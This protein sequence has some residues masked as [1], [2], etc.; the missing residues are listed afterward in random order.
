MAWQQYGS[1]WDQHLP[2]LVNAFIHVYFGTVL[3]PWHLAIYYAPQSE[4]TIVGGR[5]SAKTEG[6]ALAWATM[7]ALNPGEDQMHVSISKDQAERTIRA[8]LKWGVNGFTETF[9]E[10]R[11]FSSPSRK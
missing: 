7:V 4:I 5:G 9:I 2:Q 10:S 3:F 1:A 6:L 11:W 8:I